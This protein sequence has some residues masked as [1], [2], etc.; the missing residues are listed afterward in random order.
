MATIDCEL[1]YGE[2]EPQNARVSWGE[3][4]SAFCAGSVRLVV[5]NTK[6]NWL[7]LR[8]WLRSIVGRPWSCPSQNVLISDDGKEIVFKIGY[9]L[10]DEYTVRFVTMPSDLISSI[11]DASCSNPLAIKIENAAVA[12]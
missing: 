5:S 3:F 10:E 4:E 9:P 7:A 8:N 12:T 1:R 6:T 2:I 11:K